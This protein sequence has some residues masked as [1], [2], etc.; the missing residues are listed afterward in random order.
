MEQSRNIFNSTTNLPRFYSYL[1]YH[2]KSWV[3]IKHFLFFFLFSFPYLFIY[4]FI[5]L[6]FRDTVSLCSPGCPGTHFVDQAGLK[7]RNSPASASASLPLCLSGSLAL[8]LS[9]SLALWLSASLPLCLSASASLPLWLSAS[10]A[11]CLSASA[12]A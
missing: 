7:L 9:G 8:W 1:N 2:T 5:Y 3:E 12:S 11:L 6:V 4:L 10:L